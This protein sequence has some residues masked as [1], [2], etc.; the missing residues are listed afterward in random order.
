VVDILEGRGLILIWAMG[1]STERSSR[2]FLASK[3][4]FLLPRGAPQAAKRHQLC[5]CF[6]LCKLDHELEQRVRTGYK[7]LFVAIAKFDVTFVDSFATISS[8]SASVCLPVAYLEAHASTDNGLARMG[9]PPAYRFRLWFGLR[10]SDKGLPTRIQT[11][12]GA[13]LRLLV[14][15]CLPPEQGLRFEPFSVYE[16]AIPLVR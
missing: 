14:S 13:E 2:S 8:P 9:K 16:E 4:H 12:K 5:A 6:I 15:R 7:G 1:Q 3:R 11:L 10:L